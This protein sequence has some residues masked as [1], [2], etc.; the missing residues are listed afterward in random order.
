MSGFFS[1]SPAIFSM[2]TEPACRFVEHNSGRRTKRLPKEGIEPSP[3]CQDG[4]LNPASKCDNSLTDKALTDSSQNNLAENLALSLQEYPEL[5]QLV[6]VWPGL[7]D[8]VKRQIMEL[9][10]KGS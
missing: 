6:K 3:C 10:E 9:I 7:P 4:I 2:A 5:G 1:F 8:S